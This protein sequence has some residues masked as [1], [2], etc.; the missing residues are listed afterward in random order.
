[1]DFGYWLQ[2]L[3]LGASVFIQHEATQYNWKALQDRKYFSYEGKMEFICNGN[4]LFTVFKGKNA[5]LISQTDYFIS[6]L[7]LV[8]VCGVL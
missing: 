5:I 4:A 8:M 1:L 3:N 6:F 7:K 2:A